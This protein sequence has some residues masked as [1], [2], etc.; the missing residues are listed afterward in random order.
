[1]TE[2]SS[3][4]VL[5]IPSVKR[6]AGSAFLAMLLSLA[7]FDAWLLSEHPLQNAPTAS[8][9]RGEV[10]Q[11][12]KQYWKRALPPD[13]VLLG[14][15]LMTAPIMQAEALY[16][17]KPIS[18]TGH[19]EIAVM[20]DALSKRI[21][22]KPEVLSLSSGGQMISDAYLITKHLLCG[23]KKPTAIVY[24]V[25]PRDFCDNY[26]KA[27]DSTETFKVIA[28]P[29][30]LPD[31]LS[32]QE[33]PLDRSVGISLSRLWGLWRYKEDIR[34][35]FVLRT[36][37]LMHYCLPYVAFDRVQA[38]G[39]IRPS[40]I[41]VLPEEAK[42]SA[43]TV[44]G[45]ALE[46][47]TPQQTRQ[48]YS[49]RYNPARTE[50]IDA[51]FAYLQKL[52]QLCEKQNIPLLVVNMPLSDENREL[53]PPG[54][55]SDY[56]TRLR[57]VCGDN[58]IQFADLNNTPWNTNSN[59][60]DTVHLK[61]EISNEFVNTLADTVAHSSVSLALKGTPLASRQERDFR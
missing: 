27:I 48:Q 54:F 3:A 52:M 33:L 42:G 49:I 24:G 25:A 29:N 12:A 32:A 61:P 41:G 60:V 20:S 40:R 21:G 16:V 9:D 19:R 13:M 18:R 28:Q 22:Y 38:D 46:H 17:N 44:P 50:M 36:K 37:K 51:Q 57:G 59:F 15:S 23:D 26:C 2:K 4:R 58:D 47:M 39:T 56:L 55:Y 35:L 30:D 31:V 14:S 11:G 8:T 45:L 43:K 6:I 10:F 53:M 7:A 5:K 34:G 1:M